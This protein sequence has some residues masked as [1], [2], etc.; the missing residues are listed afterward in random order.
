MASTKKLYPKSKFDEFLFGLAY[1]SLE[2]KKEET[3]ATAAV[4]LGT[5]GTNAAKESADLCKTCNGTIRLRQQKRVECDFC[6]NSFHGNVDCAGIQPK[7]MEAFQ[8][9]HIRYKCQ[10]CI[11]KTGWEQM[12]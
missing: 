2:R 7:F 6:G 1:A 11:K 4:A 8:N 9:N 10:E 12:N 5:D 3:M